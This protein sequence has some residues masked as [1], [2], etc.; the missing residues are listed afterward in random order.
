[1]L[2]NVKFALPEILCGGSTNS[3]ANSMLS[4]AHVDSAQNSAKASCLKSIHRGVRYYGAKRQ[5]NDGRQPAIVRH[6]GLIGVAEKAAEVASDTGRT[7]KDG[8]LRRG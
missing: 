1:L 7:A 3:A 4:A 6:S 5:P 2:L 8:F